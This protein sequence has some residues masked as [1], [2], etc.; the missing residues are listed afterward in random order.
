MKRPTLTV[1]MPNYNHGK[2]IARAI[3][4]VVSQSR[5]PDEY[6]II[7]DGSTDDSADI[8]ES[9][10]KRFPY[11]RFLR[12][13]HNMG[14]MANLAKF[15]ELAKG[16]YMYGGAADDYVLPGFFEKAMRLGQQNP[17]AGVIF[18]QLVGVD[19]DGKEL[20]TAGACRW[21]L[22]SFVTPKMFLHDYLDIE[23]PGHSLSAATI[24]R[25]DALR[26]VGGFRP[27]LGSWSDTFAIR[28]I[29]LKYGAC[30]IPNRSTV[31]TANPNGFS[32]TR[33]GSPKVMLD[34][35]ARA[36]LL[37]RSD[38]FRGRFPEEYIK[39]WEKAFREAIINRGIAKC[40]TELELAVG[41]YS[42]IMALG[43]LADRSAGFCLRR[44]FKL[45]RRILEFSLGHAL[46]MYRSNAS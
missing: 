23:E 4:A 42:A 34:M 33:G 2:Y 35:V 39:R 27:E 15:M 1:C 46:Q 10:A 19:P 32:R 22:A 5:P 29:G 9:Y 41:N 26:E 43:S 21:Q 28:A 6:I 18:G 20:W 14:L 24:Y 31:W 45:L 11:I 13:E 16:D 40:L 25:L 8:I 37:M 7:D 17:E 38:E 3:E 12:H 44:S 36:A 30:Y